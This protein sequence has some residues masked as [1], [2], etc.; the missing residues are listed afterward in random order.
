MSLQTHS[1]RRASQNE[2]E[3]R[4]FI[5]LLSERGVRRY[6][7]IGARHGDSFHE[8]MLGLPVGST[9]VAVDLPGGLWGT[10]KSRDH[11]KRAVADLN[12]RG[13]KCSH[14]FGDSQTDATKRIIVGRGPYDAILIDGDHT[15][16]GVTR[17]WLQYKS[18]APLI[19]FHDIVGTGQIEKVG[20]RQVE[21]PIL[22]DRLKAQHETVEFVDA[23]SKMG[24]GV[25][26][27]SP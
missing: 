10:G 12:K 2:Y 15:L 3:L 9:G 13:Y 14:L 26:C 11:L 17:D 24:I 25:V 7:E 1:G 20:G 8:I 27:A 19:A 22:W 23:G 5:A 18:M 16:T 6:L 21:V 4:S